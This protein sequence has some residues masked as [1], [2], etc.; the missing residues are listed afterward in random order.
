MS[1]RVG[2]SGSTLLH[3]T[4]AEVPTSSARRPFMLRVTA[5]CFTLQVVID[6]PDQF[7]VSGRCDVL[8][9]SC[10][11]C[12]H[13]CPCMCR[14]WCCSVHLFC[15]PASVLLF[16]LLTP[17]QLSALLFAPL[18]HCCCSDCS[19]VIFDISVVLLLLFRCLAFVF[20]CSALVS[21]W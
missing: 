2:H 19:I 12:I 3:S 8:V 17:L 15:F 1:Q 18:V 11:S 14:Q 7:Q 9:S 6:C 10:C 20:T 5:S 13:R 21:Q 16:L 4:D